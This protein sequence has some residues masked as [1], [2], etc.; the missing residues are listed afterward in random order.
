MRIFNVV[1]NRALGGLEQSFL[2]YNKVL[3]ENG[4]GVVNI[5]S[6]LAKLNKFVDSIKLP[7][8]FPWCI[9]SK[10][11]FKLLVMIYKP[12]VIIVH[13]GRAVNFATAF[14]KNSAPVVGVTHSYSTKHI[15]KCDYLIALDDSLKKQMVENGYE[16]SKI[17]ITPNMITSGIQKNVNIDKKLVVIGAMGRFVGQKGFKYLID[18]IKMLSSKKYNVK[19]LLGGSGELEMELKNQVIGLG[20]ENFVEF[21]GWVSN[22]DK[23]FDE[24]DIFCIPSTF[25]TFGIVALEAMARG[26]PIVATNAYGFVNIFDNYKD[27]IIVNTKSSDEIAHAI[28]ELIRT[29]KLASELGRNAYKKILDK[30]D[31]KIVGAEISRILEKVTTLL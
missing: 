19:L 26:M 11:Y 24:I 2:D 15:L 9:I 23:F 29:P 1:M 20:I 12:D 21:V 17:F 4:H 14:Y 16:K 7:N 30:Y 27:T 13:G 18:A 28:E 22:K 8:L 6:S 31:E 10:I 3:E 25:E 5:T